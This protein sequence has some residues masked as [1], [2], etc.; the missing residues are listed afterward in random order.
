M[1]FQCI[2][3]LAYKAF[4][5]SNQWISVQQKKRPSRDATVAAFEGLHKPSFVIAGPLRLPA[6]RVNR[7][8]LEQS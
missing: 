2:K 1:I 7:A 6:G 3:S 8:D 5:K 4:S